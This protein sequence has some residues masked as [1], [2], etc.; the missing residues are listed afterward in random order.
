MKDHNLQRLIVIMTRNRINIL[1][2]MKHHQPIKMWIICL[3]KNAKR[4]MSLNIQKEAIK[5]AS[6]NISKFDATILDTK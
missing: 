5:F 3:L 1:K 6:H 4:L 2:T